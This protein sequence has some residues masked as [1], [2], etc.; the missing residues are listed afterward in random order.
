[1]KQKGKL[2][3]LSGFAGSGKGTIVH[4]LLERYSGEYALSVS[5]T[6]RAP[7][8]GEVHGQH[9]FFLTREQFEEMIRRDEF[10]EYA[11][12]VNNYYGTPE[13]YV[14]EQ[15][16]QGCSVILEIEIQGA[17]KV[18]EKIPEALL[19]FVTP[20]SA[21]ILEQRL[22]GRGTETDDVI[23]SRMSRAHEEAEGCEVYDYL[24]VNDDIETCI[25]QVHCII[26]SEK[27]RMKDNLSLIEQI[28][29][30][31]NVFAKGE[32]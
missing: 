22:R 20:P 4:G 24:I 28:K 16:E 2:I 10:L 23:R 8:P 13:Q 32:Q 27:C 6:T 9:Y 7:R 21:Q 1:M 14:R 30:D 17:L 5:A 15:L 26:Q 25:R 11:E 18:K 19:L 29:T 3:I 12:Y 31:L